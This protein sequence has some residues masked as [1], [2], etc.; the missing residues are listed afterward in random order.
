LLRGR[1]KNVQGKAAMAKAGGSSDG[2]QPRAAGTKHDA[3]WVDN[4][5]FE[6]FQ[7]A[8]QAV[9]RRDVGGAITGRR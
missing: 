7:P 6:A 8:H 5:D 2:S 9:D 4:R 3:M 1:R